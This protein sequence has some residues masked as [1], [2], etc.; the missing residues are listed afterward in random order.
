V[1]ERAFAFCFRSQR[2]KYLVLLL[3]TAIAATTTVAIGGIEHGPSNAP[4]IAGLA[5]ILAIPLSALLHLL[6]AERRDLAISRLIARRASRRIATD[7]A[8]LTDLEEFYTEARERFGVRRANAT[9]RFQAVASLLH[10]FFPNARP[11]AWLV[12]GVT[13]AALIAFQLVQGNVTLA[14][15]SEAFHTLSF[16]LFLAVEVISLLVAAFAEADHHFNEFRHN[17][18]AKPDD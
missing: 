5:L 13:V 12:A 2:H 6:A 9:Y 15:I 3:A 11:T 7:E 1:I 4:I 8:L 14:L 10:S 17:K 18:R 16:G